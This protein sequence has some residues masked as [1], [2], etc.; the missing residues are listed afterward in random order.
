MQMCPYLIGHINSGG[1]G[2]DKPTTLGF[3]WRGGWLLRLRW[4]KQQQ[5]WWHDSTQDWSVLVTR[6]VK[7]AV[8]M[9]ARA[10]REICRCHTP[11]H[12]CHTPVHTTLVSHC[13]CTLVYPGVVHQWCHTG[14]TMLVY[15]VSHSISGH[16]PHWLLLP[17]PKDCIL[18]KS[19]VDTVV[20][21]VWPIELS[22]NWRKSITNTNKYQS[23]MA[24]PFF[25][26]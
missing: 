13:S 5:I 4:I 8:E 21:E 18:Q 11:V 6:G 20:G 7:N 23:P 22:F 3:H 10:C 2:S 16:L 19:L 25:F 26:D 1:G 15:T 9:T 17:P 14:V 24:F 12:W